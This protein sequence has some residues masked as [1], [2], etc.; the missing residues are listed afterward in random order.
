MRLA[1][2]W[3]AIWQPTTDERLSRVEEAVSRI[4]GRVD[5]LEGAVGRLMQDKGE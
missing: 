3:R 5:T 2:L 1:D 4:V